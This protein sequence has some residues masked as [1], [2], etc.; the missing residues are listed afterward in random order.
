MYVPPKRWSEGSQSH[1]A[2][3]YGHESRGTQNQKS[4]LA[5]QQQFTGVDWTGLC[6]SLSLLDNDSLNVF[7]RQRKI[8]GDEVFYAVHVISKQ[9]RRFLF[10]KSA[11]PKWLLAL[12]Q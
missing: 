2:V 3:K 4:V 12:R 9:S 5:R 11:H 6:I 7:P 1:Q 10:L 8:V